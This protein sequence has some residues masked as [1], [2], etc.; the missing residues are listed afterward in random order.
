[1][2]ACSRQMLVAACTQCTFHE[3]GRRPLYQSLGPDVTL[4]CALRVIVVPQYSF[5]LAGEAVSC[6]ARP[7][8]PA[9]RPAHWCAPAS[10]PA[11]ALVLIKTPPHCLAC[12]LPGPAQ[13]CMPQDVLCTIAAV[14]LSF[15]AVPAAPLVDADAHC[16]TAIVFL[17]HHACRSNP[18]LRPAGTPLQNNISE[19]FCML[20]FL[21]SEGF[22][23]LGE[24]ICFAPGGGWNTGRMKR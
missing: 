14:F 13:P 16:L 6:T 7:A 17:Q 24:L 23:D 5:H 12:L 15:C 1:M 2:R 9:P 4:L 18:L 3:W 22:Q 11:H 21:G 10:A 20:L 19:I 8:L